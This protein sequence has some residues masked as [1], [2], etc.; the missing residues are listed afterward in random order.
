[1]ELYGEPDADYAPVVAWLDAHADRDAALC[2]WGNSPILY[3][4]AERPLGCRFVFANYLTGLS[5]ATPTQTDPAVDS[6][7][8]A[9]AAAWPMLAADLATRR[10]AFVVDGSP[11][12]V[13]FYG[14]YPPERYPIGK[15][16]ACDYTAEA[17]V[18]GMRIF[19]RRASS[20]CVTATR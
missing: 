1:M 15:I 6:S 13:A 4:D 14:K 7:A 9:V 3:F 8:N 18:S 16:L 10:P 19:R 11:G 5:P 12:D 20:A 17:I 2:I